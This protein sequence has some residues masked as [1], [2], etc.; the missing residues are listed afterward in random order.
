MKMKMMNG[1]LFVVL[2]SLLFLLSG[3]NTEK[4]EAITHSTSKIHS[5]NS[6]KLSPP[7][8]FYSGYQLPIL[9]SSK[10][11]NKAVGWLNNN[12]IMYLSENQERTD[13]FRYDL[14]SGDSKRLFQ[15]EYPVISAIISPDK[16]YILIHSSPSTYNGLVTVID[17]DGKVILSKEFPSFEMSFEWNKYHSKQL[18]IT[19]FKE[20]WSFQ[21]YILNVE[22]MDIKQLELRKPF[23]KWTGENKIAFL[24][25]NENEISLLAPLVQK[26]LDKDE[27]LLKDHIF[28]FDAFLNTII[29]IYASPD[30]SEAQYTFYSNEMKELATYDFPIL[31]SYSGWVVP[32]YELLKDEQTFLTMVPYKSTEA[33]SYHDGFQLLSVNIKKNQTEVILEHTNN[34]PFTCAPNGQN[35]LIGFQLENLLQLKNKTFTSLFQE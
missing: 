9:S 17:R 24:D 16:N 4:N 15:S 7:T 20:D 31:T 28:Y 1:L 29:T 25:W 27:V 2:Y 14:T 34:L 19:A 26:E 12:E 35:C 6:Q 22:N 8:S 33:D 3:C 10:E 32:N 18:L 30:T 21:S 13:I 5:V 23:G 11:M